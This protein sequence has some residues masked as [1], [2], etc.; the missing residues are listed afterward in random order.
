METKEIANALCDEFGL[1]T[2]D[3]ESYLEDVEVIT[4]G[5]GFV[6]VKGHEID[7]LYIEPDW[8]GRGIGQQLMQ[9]AIQRGG[10]RL[11]C[12]ARLRSYYEQ[13]GFTL[14]ST[15]KEGTYCCMCLE[16]ALLDLPASLRV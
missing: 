5:H 14:A 12:V 3:A 9:E 15:M 8:R 11:Q 16:D 6:L 4:V 1:S 2:E 13:I 10:N 7:K